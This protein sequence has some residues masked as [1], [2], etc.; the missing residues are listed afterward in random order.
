LEH[1]DFEV[2][3]PLGTGRFGRVYIAREKR[4]NVCIALKVLSKAEVQK[5]NN[6][7]Q[8]RREIEIQSH[9]RHPN[10]LRLYGYFYD[11]RNVYLILEYAARGTLYDELKAA[12][13]LTEQRA[14]EIVGQLARALQYCHSKDVIHRDLKPENILLSLDGQ[15]KIS[16]FGWAVHA[17]SQRR[18]TFCGTLDYLAPEMLERKVHDKNVDVWSLGIMCYEFLVGRPPFEEKDAAATWHMIVSG[19]IIYPPDTAV[20][21]AAKDLISKLLAKDPTKRI[22]LDDVLQHAWLTAHNPNSASKQRH[23]VVASV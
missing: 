10:V 18:S 15:V 8:L 9:L 22:N 21:E 5:G 4:N 16:D 3:K 6:E 23:S 17:P 12:G 13:T 2:G 7:H 19:D 1:S 14:A 11:N 20:S